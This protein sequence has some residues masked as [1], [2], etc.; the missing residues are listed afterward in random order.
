L[1]FAVALDVARVQIARGNRLGAGSSAGATFVESDA[2]RCLQ[3]SSGE[4][5]QVFSSRG[6]LSN[7]V[8]VSD[9][10]VALPVKCQAAGDV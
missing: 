5:A 1:R 8:L 2:T 4:V 3:P 7:V 9:I 10:E 6:E